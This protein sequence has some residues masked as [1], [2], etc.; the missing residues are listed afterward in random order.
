[1]HGVDTYMTFSLE[2]FEKRS[3]CLSFPMPREFFPAHVTI[4][5]ERSVWGLRRSSIS[6]MRSGAQIEHFGY[7]RGNL[8]VRDFACANVSMNIET[9]RATPMA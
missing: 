4:S 5:G 8:V 1:M 3:F 2:R 6:M 9:G 7:R